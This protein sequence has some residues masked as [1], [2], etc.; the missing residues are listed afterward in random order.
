MKRTDVSHV[1]K[2]EGDL[3]LVPGDDRALGQVFNNLI[4]NAVRAMEDTG[5]GV[6][7]VR[8]KA[9]QKTPGT[10]GVQIDV[11]D[12]GPGIPPEVRE[13][14]FEP[15]F[16]TKEDGTGLGL[17]ISKQIITMH[18]GTITLEPLPEGTSFQIIL[19]GI[20]QEDFRE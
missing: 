2:V 15:F 1:L 8:L 13:R 18:E 9:I 6:L 19:P 5:G 14:I 12:T 7:S 17:S 16:T 11:L 10:P 4:S 3:P 20:N